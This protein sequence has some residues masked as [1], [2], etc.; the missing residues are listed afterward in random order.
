[1]SLLLSKVV[2]DVDA[3]MDADVAAVTGV[4]AVVVVVEVE[5]GETLARTPT[6][7]GRRGTRMAVPKPGFVATAVANLVSSDPSARSATPERRIILLRSLWSE[8][9]LIK[10]LMRRP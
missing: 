7:S 8:R 3:L 1:M 9:S 10:P 4:A 6:T 5:A 2:V